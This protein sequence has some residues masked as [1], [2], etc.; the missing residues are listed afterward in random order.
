MLIPRKYDMRSGVVLLAVVGAHLTGFPLNR[1]LASL[2]AILVGTMTTSARYRL[3]ALCTEAPEKLGLRRTQI[4][5]EGREIKVEVWSLP[6]STLAGFMATIPP[7]LRIGWVELRGSTLVH[8]FIC[9]PWGLRDATDI[10]EFGDRG[11]YYSDAPQD[12][13]ESGN[14][15]LRSRLPSRS[16]TYTAPTWRYLSGISVADT[17][18]NTEQISEVAKSASVDAVIPGYGFLSENADFAK[19][20]EIEGLIRIGSTPEQMSEQ[21]PG[22]DRLVASL[23][24]ALKEANCIGFPVMLK[25]ITG[26]GGIGLRRCDDVE[27]LQKALESVQR[28][29]AANFGDSG[30]FLERFI[31]NAR[32]V[33]V[34]ILGDGTDRM[35]SAGEWDCSLQRRYQKIIEEIPALMVSEKTR[36]AMRAAAVRLASAIK[37]DFYFLEVNTRLQVEH[38]IT[39]AVTGFDLVEAMVAIAANKAE[40]IFREY[41]NTLPVSGISIEARLYA[42]NPL[43]SFHPCAGRAREEAIE[44][45]VSSLAATRVNGVQTNLDYLHQAVSMFQSSSYTT[46]SLGSFQFTSSSFEVLEPGS[47]TTVQDFPGR[48]GFWNAGIPP[49]GPMDHVSFRL[50]NRLAGNEEGYAALEWTIQGPVLKFHRDAI[51]AVAGA[52][53]RVEI[54]GIPAP[55]NHTLRITAGQTL[56]IGSQATFEL[57][58]SGGH[59]GRK[60]EQGGILQI[61]NQ[62]SPANDIL[63]KAPTLPIPLQPNARWTIRVVPGPHG[64]PDFFDSD[65]LD[66]GGFVV[67]CV[68]A[69]AEMWKLGQVRLGDTIKFQQISV[70]EALE[71]DSATS[72]AIERL[73]PLPSLSGSSNGPVTRKSCIVGHIH[74]KGQTLVVRQAGDCCLLLEFGESDDFN[75]RQSFEMAAFIEKHQIQPISDVEQLSLGVRTIHFK[76]VFGTLPEDILSHL[77][78]HT[79]SYTTPIHLPSRTLSLPLAFNDAATQGAFRRYAETTRSVAPWLPSNVDFLAQLNGIDDIEGT[80]R[81][82]EFLVLGLGDVFLGSPCAVPLNP[83]HR[84]FGTKYNPPRSLTPR[85]AVGIGGQYMCIYATDSPGGYQLVGR[86]VDIWDSTLVAALS[87]NTNAM[88]NQ[89]LL[90]VGMHP[91]C[92]ENNPYTFRIFDRISFYLIIEAELDAQKT[93]QLVHISDGVLDLEEYES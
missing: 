39:E 49:S 47:L 29:A 78:E 14:D 6:Q 37:F 57:G 28:Q 80:L 38:P 8:G 53:V 65:S 92:P 71:L 11:A 67:F 45:L 68:V 33:E 27:S 85:G 69:S 25:S 12:E 89:G 70:R 59:N 15:L 88:G 9:E 18:L 64:V 86:T 52:T 42:E 4:D 72:R 61:G 56:R 40:D 3:Y 83:C 75:L 51:V 50:A 32:H 5:E 63:L 54:G 2:D 16:H 46:K 87:R 21:V 31:L 17:Y 41:T 43:Q 35:I 7:P 62:A 26:G 76:C 48:T 23:D 60:L 73:K 58:K 20:V 74:H 36:A 13:A 19:A 22:S 93:E 79:R 10:T 34:Q 1:D 90:S 82:L 84:L 30:V 55:T 77:I 44:Q 24:G 66:L 81:G 91:S